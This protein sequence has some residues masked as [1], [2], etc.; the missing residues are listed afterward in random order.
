[1]A[2][3]EATAFFGPFTR[4]VVEGEKPDTAIELTLTQRG[5]RQDPVIL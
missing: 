1:M 4:M 3:D 5:P 2:Q